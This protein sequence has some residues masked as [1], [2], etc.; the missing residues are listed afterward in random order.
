[1]ANVLSQEEIDA[2]LGGLSGGQID[3]GG[4]A[5]SAE[6]EVA[7]FDFSD[8]DRFMPGRLPTL[9]TI[10]DRLARLLR[11]QLS[12]TLRRPVEIQISNQMVCS[13]GD[14]TRTLEKP[15]SLHV[16]RMEPYKGS[17]LL[18]L[19]ARLILTLVD[20]MFGGLGK[21][22]QI[23]EDRDFTLIESRVIHKITE[24]ISRCYTDSWA[25]VHPVHFNPIGSEVNVQFINVAGP[26]EPVNVVDCEIT[27]ENNKA[28]L[29]LCIPYTTIDPVKEILKGIFAAEETETDATLTAR[30]KQH[31]MESSLEVSAILGSATI[32]GR[33]LLRLK[34][35]DILQLN[36]DSEAPVEILV[37]GIRKFW[38][39]VGA[40][41][42]NRALQI[43][44]IEEQ[45]RDRP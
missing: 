17:L 10:H 15:S 44:G 1:M 11:L 6:G 5:Q 45:K 4:A 29:A 43:T 22:I 33:D 7:A 34:A 42:S 28:T 41:K 36:E 30:L 26:S 39:M 23:D 24:E 35:G 32:T 9:E 3:A 40:H 37:E 19:P 18:V 20:Y 14:F 16:L 12:T 8:Q 2:L 31:L 38:G 21:P 27:I 25:P 13:F